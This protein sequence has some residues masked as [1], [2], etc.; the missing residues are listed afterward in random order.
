MSLHYQNLG[1]ISY[2]EALQKQHEE[3]EL[4]VSGKSEGTILA[5]EH[6]P[7]ITLGKNASEEHILRSRSFLKEKGVELYQSDRGGQVTCHMPGQV[8]LYPIVSL[9]RLSLGVKAYV[10]CLEESCLDLIADYGVKGEL[11]K[12]HPGIWVLGKKIAS[13]GVR[14]KSRVTLHGLALNVDSSLELF[15]WVIPCG[16]SNGQV[17][18]LSDQISIKIKKDQLAL[19]LAKNLSERLGVSLAQGASVSSLF[20]RESFVDQVGF[21]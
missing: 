21:R 17:T 16:L 19:S 8:V 6:R 13:I 3:H 5:L 4:V 10:K 18:R 12:N 11:D 9:S 1:L 7:V 15:N 2:E 14:V 20:R